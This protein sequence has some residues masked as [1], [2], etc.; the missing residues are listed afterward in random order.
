MN[1]PWRRGLRGAGLAATRRPSEW[2]RGPRSA[3]RSAGSGRKPRVLPPFLD[4]L[5]DPCR[6]RTSSAPVVRPGMSTLSVHRL[7]DLTP[8]VNARWQV[9]YK[10]YREMHAG[11]C[12]ALVGFAE[13]H[14]QFA[15]SAAPAPQH[16]QVPSLSSQ[17]IFQG[18]RCACPERVMPCMPERTTGDRS[19]HPLRCKA[20]R[21]F[22]DQALS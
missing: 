7:Q 17:R 12:R 18:K 1:T 22:L 5:A 16:C 15:R 14:R 10:G 20:G 21:M 9:Q 3:M 6:T 11:A 13:S 4:R 19:R 2:G 8:A